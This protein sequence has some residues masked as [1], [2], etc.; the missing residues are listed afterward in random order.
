MNSSIGTVSIALKR[1]IMIDGVK[2]TELTMREPLV[3]DQ[4]AASEVKGS[5]AQQEI[6]LFANLCQVSIDDIKAM[7]LKNYQQ[8]Q[9][10][11]QGFL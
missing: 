6:A 3:S 7:T 5:S 9:E 2:R 1:P 8:I 11:Y 4:L 10:A